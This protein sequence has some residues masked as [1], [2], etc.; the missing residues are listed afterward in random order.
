MI[1]HIFKMLWSQRKYFA[2]IFVEQL[3][4]FIILMLC[5]VS[6]AQKGVQYYSPGLLQTDHTVYF[7]Y[8]FRQDRPSSQS[9][10]DE[11]G[12]QMQ[13]VIHNLREKPYVTAISESYGFLPYL[14]EL[15]GKDSITID[16]RKVEVEICGSDQFGWQVLRPKLIEGE[17]LTDKML[18]DG[19]YPSVITRQ[20]AEAV[21]W[22]QT[23]GRK[24]QLFS[25]PF[26][27]VGLIEG[28]KIAPFDESAPTIIVSGPL[29]VQMSRYMEYGARLKPNMQ[30]EFFKDYIQEFYKNITL[31]NVEPTMGDLD[32]RKNNMLIT[33]TLGLI[34]RS[35]PTVFF[36]IFG[37]IG[38]FGLFWLYSKKRLEE[39]ALRRAIGAT[40][41]RLVGM[42]MTESVVL[43]LLAAAP[44]ILLV[45]LTQRLNIVT[46]LGILS[47]LTVMLLFSVFSAWYPAWKVSRVS[48]AEALHNE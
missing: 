29:I 14:R 33:N 10:Y 38:T 41:N 44:G 20:L 47:T 4:I 46:L 23:V 6:V 22:Q 27:V 39:F 18:P 13:N 19:S 17:W 9:Q 26:T 34:F 7:G 25:K 21:G 8:M 40:K 1:Q 35:V 15:Y 43:T 36:L 16:Q 42:V 30:D 5:M 11:M 24:I 12:K 32:K 3:L 48:P 37:F 31:P 45:V 2:G 28:K